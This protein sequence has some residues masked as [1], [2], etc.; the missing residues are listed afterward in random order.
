MMTF[1]PF[2]NY[3]KNICLLM[4]F[5][6]FCSPGV[7]AQHD[8]SQYEGWKGE[9]TKFIQNGDFASA[10]ATLNGMEN[11]SDADAFSRDAFL[12]IMRRLN[13]EFPYNE[14]EIREQL[15]E[16]FPD[17]TDEQMTQWEAK[18]YLEMRNIDGEKRYFS[19]AVRN[20]FLLDPELAAKN[21]N[22]NRYN[23]RIAH[24]QEILDQ[25]NGR[26]NLTCETNY[27][28]NY[29]LTVPAN[30]VPEGETIRCWLPFAQINCARQKN[31]KLI[32]TNSENPIVSP[33][34]DLQRTIYMEKTAVKDQPTVFEI[35]FQTVGYAQ[36][37]SYDWLVEK[38]RPYPEKC[39][40]VRLYTEERL[41][42][43]IKSDAFKQLAR[44]IVG[45]ETNP[46]KKASLLYDW[47]D[48]SFPWASAN[49]YGVNLNIP[50][51][52]IDKGHGDCGMV[53]LLLISLLRCEG[54]PAKWQSGWTFSN[55]KGGLHDWLEIYFE[56]IGWV[57]CDVSYGKLP[58]ENPAIANFYKFGHDEK[59]LIVNQDYAQPL[60]PEKTFFR[61]EPLDFQRGEVEWDG[62]NLYFDQWDYQMTVETL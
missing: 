5:V 39:E 41:P 51:Y 12:E 37:Y 47:V 10:T 46:V 56:G 58:S 8:P 16:K 32:S 34:D 40:F 59:R 7:F 20:L 48:D 3:W 49:E 29:I 61:S 44:E 17:L 1:Y 36:A 35:Q 31:V 43:I 57:P 13:L 30:E 21:R 52:V 23:A 4:A 24:C 33:E 53:S 15:K 27:K 42:H 38:V 18:Q 45:E 9:I 50:Q 19:S 26:G 28:I 62:G 22:P 25:S 14:N 6:L 55:G 11:L 54:I 60:T 2:V